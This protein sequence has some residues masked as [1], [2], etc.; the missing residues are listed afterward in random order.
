MNMVAVGRVV[1]PRAEMFQAVC[2]LGL[3]DGFFIKF[4][5]FN[6]TFKR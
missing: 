5:P 3:E 6:P 4:L 1:K 2:K